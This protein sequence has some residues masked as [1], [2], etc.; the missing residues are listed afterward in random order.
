M[1]HAVGYK[2]Y[3]DILWVDRKRRVPMMKVLFPLPV[4]RVVVCSTRIFFCWNAYVIDDDDSSSP[5]LG[6]TGAGL[7][8][9]NDTFRGVSEAG[10]VSFCSGEASCKV[11]SRIAVGEPSS[12]LPSAGG[13]VATG[14][15]F[16][17][18]SS[19]IVREC[20]RSGGNRRRNQSPNWADCLQGGSLCRPVTQLTVTVSGLPLS[21]GTGPTL[22]QRSMSTKRS[23]R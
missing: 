23:F 8:L 1:Q 12:T 11:G 7:L 5:P 20:S 6:A 17:P 16:A 15:F 21:R 14:P 10:V 18:A 13:T 19:A 2:V 4:S 22:V 9:K 3:A